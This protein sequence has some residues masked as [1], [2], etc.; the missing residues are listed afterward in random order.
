MNDPFQVDFRLK[1]PL[2]VYTIKDRVNNRLC[3][4]FLQTG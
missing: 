2:L 3:I 1:R 4:F